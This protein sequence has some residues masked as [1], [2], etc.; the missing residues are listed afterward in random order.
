MVEETG[1]AG[2]ASSA[3]REAMARALSLAAD[4]AIVTHPNPRVGCVLVRSATTSP[5]TISATAMNT[6]SSINSRIM[7]STVTPLGI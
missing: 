1:V 3:E 6:G 7:I 4:P 2:Q 5:I